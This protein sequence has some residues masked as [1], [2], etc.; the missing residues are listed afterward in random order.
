MIDKGDDMLYGVF[1]GDYFRMVVSR[2]CRKYERVMS[3]G[4]DDMIV[5]A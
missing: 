4:L 1:H 3:D 2:A 5:I